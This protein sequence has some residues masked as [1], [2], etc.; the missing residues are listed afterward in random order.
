M[1]TNHLEWSDL[2]R[3]MESGE[4]A[5]SELE[6]HLL[7]C[8]RCARQAVEVRRLLSTLN[9]ARLSSPPPELVERTVQRVRREAAAAAGVSAASE[10]VRPVHDIPG[11]FRSLREIW[12]V[13]VGDSLRPSPALRGGGAEPSRV[14]VFETDAYSI[15]L[16]VE[17]SSTGHPTGVRGQVVPRGDGALP[18]HG[19]VRAMLREH[20]I[21]TD[22][23]EFGEFFLEET[24][25]SSLEGIDLVL[26]DALIRIQIPAV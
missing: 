17:K 3:W 14:M 5:N 6:S 7:T 26:G 16:S 23:S 13:F 9:D 18:P 20:E 8:R 11:S 21:S 4:G 24:S 12:A 22:V 19:C 1:R 15:A 10:S 2:V 25:T